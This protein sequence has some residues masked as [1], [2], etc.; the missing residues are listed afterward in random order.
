MSVPGPDVKS[1]KT[2]SDWWNERVG[3]NCVSITV[4]LENLMIEDKVIIQNGRLSFYGFYTIFVT[5][6]QLGHY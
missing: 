2:A 4:G 5:R 1:H 3:N 6:L